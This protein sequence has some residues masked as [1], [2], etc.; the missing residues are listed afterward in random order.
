LN[1]SFTFGLVDNQWIFLGLDDLL[2]GLFAYQHLF[3]SISDLFDEM[4]VAEVH[5]LEVVVLIQ[6]LLTIL[7]LHNGAMSAEVVLGSD[8][9]LLL[10]NVLVH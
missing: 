6:H 3:V 7:G 4:L 5:V 8:N 2:S 9:P 1:F 10:L